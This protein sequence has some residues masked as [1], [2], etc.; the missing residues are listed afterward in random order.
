MKMMR[1]AQ[2]SIPLIAVIALA[3]FLSASRPSYAQEPADAQ[4][5]TVKQY[6]QGCHN[7]R[8]KTG[9]FSFQ[10]ITAESVSKDPR[11]FEKAVMKLRGRVMPPPGAKQPD[12]KTV[13]S[14][15]TWLEDSLDK[16]PNQEHITDQGLLHRLNRR[17]YQ[18]AVRD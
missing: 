16:V 15:V 17:E 13:D 2:N 8:A 6:C 14:L 1:P 12:G 18:N 4:L 7:D 9:G 3:G 10:G 5:A 11:L